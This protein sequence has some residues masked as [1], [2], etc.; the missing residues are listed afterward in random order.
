MANV[1]IALD[2][3][4]KYNHVNTIKCSSFEELSDVKLGGNNLNFTILHYNIRSLQAHYDELCIN[5]K[6]LNKHNNIGITILSETWNVSNIYRYKIDGFQIY[7]NEAKYSKCDGVVIYREDISA[8]VLIKM[9][10]VVTALEC[11]FTFNNVSLIITGVYRPNPSNVPDFINNLDVYLRSIPKC[12]ISLLVGDMNIDLAQ[13][14]EYNN[15]R[16]INMLQQNGYVCQINIPTRVEANS[17]TVIDHIFLKANRFI[18][19][20]SHL[21]CNPILLENC[22]TDHYPV[23]LSI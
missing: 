1:D 19:S 5:L 4:E 10:G 9:I 14:C 18:T 6:E 22:M 21:I 16:Y 3:L 11:S 2:I 13:E 7:Y 12:D 20:D 8:N 17:F 15:L 23:L